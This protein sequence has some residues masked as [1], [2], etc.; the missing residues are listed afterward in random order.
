VRESLDEGDC[1]NVVLLQEVGKATDDR[2]EWVVIL[3]RDLAHLAQ[4]VHV[5]DTAKLVFVEEADES[6]Q[7]N[8]GQLLYH[9]LEHRQ[10][11]LCRYKPNVGHVGVLK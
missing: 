7:L 9:F 1:T 6:L 8:T 4:E 2:F 3:V 10:K 11:S 5:V